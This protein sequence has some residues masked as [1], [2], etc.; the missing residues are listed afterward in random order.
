MASPDKRGGTNMKQTSDTS[1]ERINDF[2]NLLSKYKS[3][4]A[5]SKL[6]YFGSS[7]TLK[8]IHELYVEKQNQ[9]GVRADS[10][11]VFSKEFKK[12][13][14]GIYIPKTDTCKK[15]DEADFRR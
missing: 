14:V 13:N 2:F 12:Y 9:D 1:I 15:C 10:Y 8:K 3:Q 6:V 7:L 5:D 11:S 4:Y